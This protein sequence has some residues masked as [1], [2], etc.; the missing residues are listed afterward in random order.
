MKLLAFDFETHLIGPEPCGCGQIH[1]QFPPAVCL[2]WATDE[3]ESGIDE[4]TKGLLR[5]HAALTDPE[6]IIIGA[7]TAFD[8]HVACSI[9]PRDWDIWI[10]NWDKAYS[11]GRVRDVLVRAR[12][13]NLA[14]GRFKF[15]RH[16][17]GRAVRVAHDLA[18]VAHDTLGIRLDKS[19]DTWR[20]RYSE[21]DG[22]P[23]DRWPKEALEYAIRDA[24]ITG[25]V[26]EAQENWREHKLYK[27]IPSLWA[28][29][30]ILPDGDEPDPL[31]PEFLENY[32]ALWLGTMS[33]HVGV[34][35]DEFALNQYEKRSLLEYQDLVRVVRGHGLLRRQYWR[36]LPKLRDRSSKYA[37][38][39]EWRK[40][41][42]ALDIDDP[43]ALGAWSEL[44]AETLVRWKNAKNTKTA[45]ERVVEV[46]TRAGRTVPHTDSWD[47]DK[48]GVAEKIAL[49]VDTCRIGGMLEIELD[50][51]EQKLQA[52]ADLVHVSKVVNTDIPKIRPGIERPLHTHYTT[53]LETGRT[54]SANPPLQ[55]RDRG[56]EEVAGD[57]E[58]F[59]PTRPGY[60]Y[61]D[62]D[63]PQ[64]ELYC[65]AQLCKW[66]V[67]FSTMGDAMLRGED[68]HIAFGG[69][70]AGVDTYAEA[71][72]LHNAGKLKRERMAAKGANFGRPGGLGPNTMVGY[73]AKSYGVYLPLEDEGEKKGWRTLLKMWSEQWAEMPAYFNYINGCESYEGSGDF[74]V[75]TCST[76]L[77][78]AGATYTAACN[79]GYQSL[80]AAVAKLAG[81]YLW[82]ASYVRGVD[83]V[84]FGSGAGFKSSQLRPGHFIHDQFLCEA[85]E[86]KAAA[87]LPRIEF[88][89]RKAA[90]DLLPDY[91]ASMAAKTHALI[92]RRWSKQSERLEDETGKIAVWD[93]ARLYAG[94]EL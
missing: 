30:T 3:G 21:L 17:D 49:D 68:L 46:Y 25:M 59:V 37:T 14:A 77:L 16:S 91:G 63:Y 71:L 36:D 64:L 32:H 2:T 86:D 8:V 79:H 89:C 81:L 61:I 35:I 65:L 9:Y 12:L 45:A 48:H 15:H 29:R 93:D 27:H 1:G 90:T 28:G 22:V 92:A 20:L 73:A 41:C 7:N 85:Q 80:G 82:R 24:E 60:V 33:G 78:R 5:L 42:A 38:N 57:R 4:P 11:E 87:Q 69:R 70:I 75:A 56:D 47:E 52:Y 94:D 74:L 51:P 10:K 72:A 62:I 18:G 34:M 13:L 54:S 84:L 66:T 31:A 53:L 67:G 58:C 55:N 44:F 50:L 6:C 39:L 83:P 43:L 88:W 76:G 23:F 40:L 26:F 19:A